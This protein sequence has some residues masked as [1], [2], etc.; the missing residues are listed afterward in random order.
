MFTAESTWRISGI[1][2]VLNQMT[3]TLCGAAFT[4]RAAN[5][6]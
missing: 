6:A 1:I 4:S 5:R 3:P 2:Q